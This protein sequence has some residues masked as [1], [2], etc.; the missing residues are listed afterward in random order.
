LFSGNFDSR[1]ER[2]KRDSSAGFEISF[3]QE[4]YSTK[5][6]GDLVDTS[7]RNR[8]GRFCVLC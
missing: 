3:K 8:F 4:L 1:M 6:I 7:S 5:L 2:I